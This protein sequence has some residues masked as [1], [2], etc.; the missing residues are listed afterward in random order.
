[1][2]PDTTHLIIGV[3]GGGTGCRVGIQTP[4]GAT[5]AEARGGAA[6][7]TTDPEGAVH[8]VLAALRAAL[9]GVGLAEDALR[10]CVAHVGLAGVLGD[11]EARALSAAL[12]FD[13]L[14]V[15]DDR[16]TTMAGALGSG[17][18]ALAAIGTG[19]FVARRREG[20]ARF[21]GG[22]GLQVGD[23]ASG[24]WLG[25]ALLERCL[26]VVD[27]VAEN[28]DLAHDT[29]RRFDGDARAI[30]T[31]ARQATP[32]DYAALAP[33]VINAA[34]AG[35]AHGGALMR[36]GADYL[37]SCL[38]VDPL[39]SEDTL[40]LTGGVGPHYAPYLNTDL[41]DRIRPA[42]GTALDGALHLAREHLV[43]TGN[44]G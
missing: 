25:R 37:M 24:A 20:V 8:N 11:V 39:A 26:L 14:S 38:Q 7:F 17:D 19:S 6:N 29:L 2:D 28:S 23:Q 33:L 40:C 1:M 36:T 18:G 42:L 31:F 13:R 34:R 21:F 22:W 3:D 44:P 12:P 41:Q 43:V 9:S 16:A 30:V 4:S 15:S 27:G 10:R 35:D 32:G 5:V